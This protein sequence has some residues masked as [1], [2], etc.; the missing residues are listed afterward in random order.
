MMRTKLMVDLWRANG[1]FLTPW[2]PDVCFGYG[3]PFFTF[4][5]PLGYYVSAFVYT[6]LDVTFGWAAKL[7][8]YLSFYL[9]GL[10]VYAYVVTIGLRE[11]WDRVHWWGVAAGILFCLTPY[12]ICDIFIRSSLAESWGFAFVPA[13]FWTLE[14]SRQNW[15]SGTLALAL[16]VALLMLSHNITALYC[17]LFAGIYVLLT[18]KPFLWPFR[19]A[20]GAILGA[21]LSAYYWL[22]AMALKES[23][24]VSNPWT[25][26][27]LPYRVIEHAVY[28]KQH[29]LDR[30]GKGPSVGGPDEDFGITIGCAVVMAVA[31]TLLAAVQRGFTF[32]QRWR[33]IVLLILLAISLIFISPQMRWDKI[34]ALFL[35]IQFPWRL[36]IFCTFFGC[37]A[38]AAASPALNRWLHPMA[39]CA[40]AAMICIPPMAWNLKF[41]PWW[42]HA[43]CDSDAELGKFFT[44]AEGRK[45]YAGSVAQEFSPVWSKGE[46]LEPDFHASHPPPKDRLTLVSGMI[47]VVRYAHSGTEYSYSYSSSV[48]SVVT[49]SVFD[50]PGWA[51]TVDGRD[52][53]E[54]LG[55]DE[56]GLVRISIPAGEHE[57]KLEY[58]NSPIGNTANRISLITLGVWYGLGLLSAVG[59]RRKRRSSAEILETKEA[60][61]HAEPILAVGLV[62]A[63]S[64]DMAQS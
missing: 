55:R 56:N 29:L 59:D 51:V 8:F 44:Y 62:K 6:G 1:S 25:M 37:V 41:E 35:Y 14:L 34:P 33:L 9:S 53:P 22:P 50:F 26:A 63:P 61:A 45:F 46:Y 32:R 16:A 10:F 4:Y 3:W 60:P 28:W 7:S 42:F 11:R 54:L 58:R 31:L 38:F 21:G 64:S 57:L 30:W 43:K 36:L 47:Q 15:K 27:A 18:W 24:R 20:V 40:V 13:V 48:D 17:A 2:F 23:V 12:H 19:A 5:A 52:A 39:I 49:I